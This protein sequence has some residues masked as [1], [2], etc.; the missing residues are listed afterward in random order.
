MYASTRE[1]YGMLASTFYGALSVVRW[2]CQHAAHR[3]EHALFGKPFSMACSEIA[4]RA[5]RYIAQ[6]SCGEDTVEAWLGT[7]RVFHRPN[8]ELIQCLYDAHT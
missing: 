1:F 4:C 8:S 5:H 3:H 2:A 6:T 7:P